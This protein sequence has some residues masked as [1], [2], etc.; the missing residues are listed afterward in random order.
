[1]GSGLALKEGGKGVVA[2]APA[3][4]LAHGAVGG[5]AV[6]EAVQLPARISDLHPGLAHVDAQTLAHLVVVVVVTLKGLLLCK[7]R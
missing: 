3:S 1:M 2:T 4:A 6:L 7:L 5:D